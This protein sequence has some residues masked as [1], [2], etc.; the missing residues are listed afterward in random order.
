MTAF[1]VASP[2]SKHPKA[3]ASARHTG[4][5][6]ASAIDGREERLVR[7]RWGRGCKNSSLRL[8]EQRARRPPHRGFC[9]LL[10]GGRAQRASGRAPSFGRA[11]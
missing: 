10:S 3:V 8:G 9:R 11:S 6:T 1:D 4:M 5:T 2:C 7:A